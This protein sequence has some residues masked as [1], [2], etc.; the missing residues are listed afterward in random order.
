MNN[1]ERTLLG[2]ILIEY[3]LINS[4]QLQE[5][6]DIQVNT[7]EKL[8][9]ILLSLGYVS[10][11]DLMAVLEYQTG[12]PYVNLARTPIEPEIAQLISQSL[13]MRHKVI[14]FGKRNTKL[15][16]AMADPK[17]VLA[18]DDVRIATGMDITPVLAA[19][20][21]LMMVIRQYLGVKESLDKMIEDFGP[22]VE[23]EEE[24]EEEEKAEISELAEAGPIV[25]LVNSIIAQAV[26]N[27]ASDVHVEPQER[28]VVV[29]YRVDGM[30]RKAMSS[31][32]K[33]QASLISCLKIMSNMDIAEKRVP[34]DGRIAMK[35]EGREI[36]LRVNSLPTV[37][38]EKIV[39]R[40]LDKA[41]SLRPIDSLGMQPRTLRTFRGLIKQPHGM[42]LIT[43]PTGSGKT[44][45]LYSVLRELNCEETNII[46]VEDPVEYTLPGINQVNVNPKAGLTFA[47]GLRAILRQDPDVVMIGEIR[48]NET[49]SI[50]I[51]AALTG[52]LVLSTLHTNSAAATITRLIDMGIEPYMISASI[53][54]VMAQHLVRKIC[55]H[56][57]QTYEVSTN[58]A[59]QLMLDKHATFYRG[60][61][62]GRCNNTGYKGRVAIQELLVFTQEVKELILAGASAA[63]I[64][65]AAIKAGMHSLKMDGIAKAKEGLTTLE[66]IMTVISLD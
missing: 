19:E 6:L 50:A 63:E 4:E 10:E 1:S 46:S 43:G 36:D 28:E 58:L 25:Q 32:K 48:D 40:I 16:L 38:G 35:V 23:N 51:G 18:I 20:S 22:V 5:A 56:C 49:V 14:P 59:K 29:R 2:E 21:D 53:T 26:A 64:E 17:N 47:S 12:I 57:K 62:C 24:E 15:I 27:R 44:T 52:H 9:N 39:I 34:Q 31:P 37:H 60:K 54:G 55:P 42:L 61:G 66:E 45:A 41:S 3:G 7:R 33:T 13:A 11:P 65:R 8:G 30:L